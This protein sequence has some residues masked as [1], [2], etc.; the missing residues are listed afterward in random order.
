MMFVLKFIIQRFAVLQ[1]IFF[2]KDG[3]ENGKLFAI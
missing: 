3:F 2:G 1:G